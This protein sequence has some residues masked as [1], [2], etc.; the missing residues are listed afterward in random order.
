M[1]KAT[2]LVAQ[3]YECFN[4]NDMDTIRNEVFHPDLVW[5]L[6]GHHPLAGTKNG[7]E[8]VIA[9]FSQLVKSGIKV[10][11]IKIDM[12][13]DDGAIEVHRG[14]GTYGDAKLDATN[15]T[16]YK[17]KDDRIHTVQ[18]FIG[19]QHGADAYFNAVYKLKPIPHRLA[20]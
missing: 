5:H 6:P 13:G 3:M 9:F 14:Y 10:D 11:L 8:E 17:V 20:D 15:C 19:N 2:D 7:A 1:K 12:F 18:V 4:K 16:Y